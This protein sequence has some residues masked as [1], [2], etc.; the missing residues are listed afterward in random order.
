ML[1]QGEQKRK[2]FERNEDRNVGRKNANVETET[3]ENSRV[4]MHPG[5]LGVFS[6]NSRENTKYPKCDC[7]IG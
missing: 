4:H 2:Y 5:T 3:D 7:K 6:G 1:S